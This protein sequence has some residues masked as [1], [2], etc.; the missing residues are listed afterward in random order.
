MLDFP[1]TCKPAR[2]ACVPASLRG[3]PLTLLAS[4]G[5][6]YSC[7]RPVFPVARL[8]DH[9]EFLQSLL[10]S[11]VSS[12]TFCMEPVC[13]IARFVSSSPWSHADCLLS[14]LPASVQWTC[15]SVCT[16]VGSL[17]TYP[18]T[19][20]SPFTSTCF[21]LANRL[22]SLCSL[23]PFVPFLQLESFTRSL[24]LPPFRP[25][26][27]ARVPDCQISDDAFFPAW[28]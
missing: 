11:P 28:V 19:M 21:P 20:L 1:R 17:L 23:L 13:P 5:P 26:I 3:S 25:L 4:T 16:M 18:Q 2:Q 27:R 12:A 9:T 24:F 15:L 7:D 6:S 8:S 22:K 10:A 14:S